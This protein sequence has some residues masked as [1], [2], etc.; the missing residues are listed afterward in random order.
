MNESEVWIR[1]EAMQG[2]IAAEIRV[3]LNE[4]PLAQ[5]LFTQEQRERRI[6]AMQ[7]CAAE[8]TSD[9]D[10]HESWMA[11][12][13]QWGWV[14]GLEFDPAKKTHPNLLPWDKLPEYVKSKARIFDN[15]RARCAVDLRRHEQP[16]GHRSHMSHSSRQRAAAEY[17]RMNV[18]T[19]DWARMQ[20]INA[21]FDEAAEY[22]RHWHRGRFLE[23]WDAALSEDMKRTAAVDFIEILPA[24]DPAMTKNEM[25]ARSLF[26]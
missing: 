2:A 15:R 22:D 5:S 19:P 17:K 14:Y 24:F 11:M 8:Q 18:M 26:Q 9:A 6:T 21:A 25:K 16:A 20:I 7:K 13:L 4:A 23:D 1:M 10:R 3:M 12:H